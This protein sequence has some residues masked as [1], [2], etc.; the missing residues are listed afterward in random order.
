MNS[1]TCNEGENRNCVPSISKERGVYQV[2]NTSVTTNETRKTNPI[3]NAESEDS[4]TFAE[5]FYEE[6]LSVNESTKQNSIEKTSIRMSVKLGNTE[7]NFQEENRKLPPHRAKMRRT[8]FETLKGFRDVELQES[9]LALDELYEYVNNLEKALQ[10]LPQE[11]IL[12]QFRSIEF[13]LR[14]SK[15]ST[16]RH[17]VLRKE[18]TPSKLS[19]MSQ[20]DLANPEIQENRKHALQDRLERADTKNHK[21]DHGKGFFSCRRCGKRE[22][23]FV[24]L[25]TSSGD[26]PSTK[27]VTCQS[28][29]LNWKFR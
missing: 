25:Q 27:F 8:L 1:K 17:A 14:D 6:S 5:A 9:F 18:I 26:E 24:E 4:V 22:T 15:N 19:L 23:T 7:K 20:S 21:L 16:L 12:K 10:E 28:C 11:K 13:N 29:G 2:G 3:I